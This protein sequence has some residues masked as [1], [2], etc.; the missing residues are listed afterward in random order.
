MHKSELNINVSYGA[1]HQKSMGS[2]GK[3]RFE[4]HWAR[5]ETLLK[6]LLIMRYLK[7]SFHWCLIKMEIQEYIQ[8]Q[9]MYTDKYTVHCLWELHKIKFIRNLAFAGPYPV[10]VR[11]IASVSVCKKSCLNAFQLSTIFISLAR[12]KTA[13]SFYSLIQNH[14]HIKRGAKLGGK[15]SRRKLF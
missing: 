5:L 1:W 2:E 4:M 15:N 12:G 11:H 6:I 10:A 14:Y 9:S 3:T 13:L 7:C 8:W